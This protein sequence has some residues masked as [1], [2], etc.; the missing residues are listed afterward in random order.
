MNCGQQNGLSLVKQKK[1]TIRTDTTEELKQM[2][3]NEKLDFTTHQIP[4]DKNLKDRQ[5]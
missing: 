3:P 5:F 2:S 4:N 1:E